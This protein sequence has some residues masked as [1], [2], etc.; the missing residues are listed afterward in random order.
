MASENIYMNHRYMGE[1]A[2]DYRPGK[3]HPIYLGDVLGDRYHVFR[4]L[5]SGTQCTVWLARDKGTLTGK[6]YVVI[7]VFA[8]DS[9][10]PVHRLVQFLQPLQSVDDPATKHLELTQDSFTIHGSNGEHFC[11]VLEPLGGS[12]Y[13]LMDEAFE[14]RYLPSLGDDSL[15]RA[16]EGDPWTV[17][18]AKRACWQILQGLNLL[19]KQQ[20]AHRDLHPNNMCLALAG[21]MSTLSENDIQ[22]EVWPEEKAERGNEPL[23][24]QIATKDSSDES[25]SD[26]ESLS[27]YEKEWEEC[28]RLTAEH[29]EACKPGDVTAEPHSIEWNKGNFFKS[30]DMIE[31][32][33]RKDGKTLGPGEARYTVAPTSLPGDFDLKKVA[34]PDA[35]FRVVLTDLG[36]AC[37]FDE[38]D[39][40]TVPM[41]SEFNPPEAIL[42]LPVPPN[43]DIFS[44]GMLFWEIVMLRRLIEHKIELGDPKRIYL[45]NRQLRDLAQRLGPVPPFLRAQ[46]PDAD[47]FVDP[48]G[49]AL[50]MQERD[51]DVYTPDHFEYGDIWH[52]ARIRKP[53]D[54]S[55]DDMEVFVG[56]L[57]K[58]LHW[59]PEQRPSTE[60]LLQHPW[61]KSL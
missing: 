60:E 51:E 36:F 44:L 53:W 47:E 24:K 38:F 41:T 16:V 58:M 37:R 57:L 46:W 48:E 45:K 54:M 2:K 3:F 49:N 22:K 11:T 5:G 43:G 39:K 27:E 61:F 9:S 4:K 20:V 33:H 26:D 50:D 40:R 34:D 56:M 59:E 28:K 13:S 55:D 12:L 23:P 52:H 17:K 8:A 15:P 10:E 7:K 35:P 42:G 31:I 18:F 1:H 30:R 29:W 32:I 14:I 19:H 25:E 6:R 21:D